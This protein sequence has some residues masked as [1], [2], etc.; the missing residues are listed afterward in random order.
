M[1]FAHDDRA[2]RQN[3][4]KNDAKKISEIP[5]SRKS[6][7]ANVTTFAHGCNLRACGNS[8]C[9]RGGDVLIDQRRRE[10]AGD[11]GGVVAAVHLA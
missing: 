9:R 3:P 1:T 10:L 4:Q 8:S 5:D 6:F 7:C 2:T 11:Q